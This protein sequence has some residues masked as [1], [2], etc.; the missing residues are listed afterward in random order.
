MIS[1]MDKVLD[2]LVP[3]ATASADTSYY[4][5]CGACS[6]FEAAQAV[7]HWQKLCHIVGGTTGCTG[8]IYFSV[9]CA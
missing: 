3:R 7:G 2:R 9:G 6:Y 5:N 8:C 4:K 1:L